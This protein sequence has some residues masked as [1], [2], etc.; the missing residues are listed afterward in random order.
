MMPVRP[1]MR[2]ALAVVD[3]PVTALSTLTQRLPVNVPPVSAS[4]PML[5]G[6]GAAGFPC[7]WSLRAKVEAEPLADEP[8]NAVSAVTAPNAGMPWR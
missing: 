5:A 7:V 4:A 8:P 2:S 1:P 6:V 3:V